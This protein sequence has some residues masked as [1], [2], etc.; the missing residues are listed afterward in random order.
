M[1]SLA[2]GALISGGAIST[3]GGGTVGPAAGNS[4]DTLN[5][6]TITAGSTYTIGGNAA[7]ALTGT[8][9]NQ[10]TIALT[11]GTGN[12]TLLVSDDYPYSRTTMT[13]TGGGTVALSNSANN[14]I[15]D[16]SG[17]PYGTLVNANNLIA[18]AGNIGDGNL[19]LDNQAAGTIDAD[20]TLPADSATVVLHQRRP[21]RG[22]G[23]PGRWNC[24]P[25]S[26]KPP[27]R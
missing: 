22:D 27:E 14:L 21:D 17:H 6:V 16:P 9:T 13:L 12:A 1:V 7:T 19:V 11:A 25:V 18:G 26:R 24:R 2:S 8:I 10:G 5:N 20:Q 4:N 3:A 15:Y 23:R